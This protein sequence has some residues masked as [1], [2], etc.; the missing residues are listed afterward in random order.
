[1]KVITISREYGAGGH[2]IGRKVAEQLGIEFYDRDI[3]L[4]TASESGL[5]IDN[6]IEEEEVMR[7]RDSVLRVIRPAA[8]DIK[9]TVFE[10]ERRAIIDLAKKGPC[11]LLGRCASVTLEEAGIEHL[12]VFLYASEEARLPRVM[13]LCENNDA[14]QMKRFMKKVDSAR[15]AYY[16]C[17]TGK[18]WGS[19]TDHALMLDTG[20]FS[21]DACAALLVRAAESLS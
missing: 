4:S 12:S 21:A 7:K 3:I 10:Y 16:E 5:D 6:V 15:H 9:D 11:V 20:T 18:H 13:K 19:Y 8:F 2:T 14:E 17:Y 1:M